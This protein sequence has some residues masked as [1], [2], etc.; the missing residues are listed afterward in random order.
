M[1]YTLNLVQSG[2]QYALFFLD[3][4]SSFIETGPITG[5][6]QS[7]GEPWYQFITG[8]QFT[9][10]LVA[11]LLIY[12][13]SSN[14]QYSGWTAVTSGLGYNTLNFNTQLSDVQ[15]PTNFVAV[16]TA[17]NE[18]FASFTL[19]N[20]PW[21]ITPD[22]S[23]ISI[24]S[25]ISGAGPVIPT[26]NADTNTYG[27]TFT[28]VPAGVYTL[29][30]YT[31]GYYFN[32]FD[33]GQTALGYMGPGW[34][35]SVSPDVFS[36]SVVVQGLPPPPPSPPPPALPAPNTMQVFNV[37]AQN[38]WGVINNMAS[39]GISDDFPNG[40][41]SWSSTLGSQYTHWEM[42]LSVAVVPQYGVI[43]AD[44]IEAGGSYAP[45]QYNDTDTPIP[46]NIALT[47][48]S[49]GQAYRM[50]A[51]HFM[52]YLGGGSSGLVFDPL[53]NI[54]QTSTTSDHFWGFAVYDHT[55]NAL[56]E[57]ISYND[58]IAA[59][60]SAG[61]AGASGW[62]NTGATGIENDFSGFVRNVVRTYMVPVPEADDT[63]NYEFDV[64]VAIINY[65]EYNALNNAYQSA[66]NGG[67]L[68]VAFASVAGDEDGD[69]SAGR[70]SGRINQSTVWSGTEPVTVNGIYTVNLFPQSGTS[71]TYPFPYEWYTGKTWGLPFVKAYRFNNPLLQILHV[72]S[73][74][75]ETFTDVVGASAMTTLTAL[76]DG[77]T[78][79][80]LIDASGP[81]SGTMEGVTNVMNL[82]PPFAWVNHNIAAHSQPS[83]AL[84]VFVQLFYDLRSFFG[85][86]L[87]ILQRLFS[88]I[89]NGITIAF[90]DFKS[91][92]SNP[93]FDNV[94][95]EFSSI[96]EDF[97][98]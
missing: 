58:C 94:I 27:A 98:V 68:T 37:F 66:T 89:R 91:L 11:Y 50:Y 84:G 88:A 85:R 86:L 79:G 12:G 65:N 4:E 44:D 60:V 97:A 21:Q 53:A 8:Q 87:G 67:T 16:S 26:F 6:T 90:G 7:D 45:Y 22:P 46:Y 34:V 14:T 64:S 39:K 13:L 63:G 82:Y 78:G 49:S 17:D 33:L 81:S 96:A 95:E 28:G 3:G 69:T 93:A 25:P 41:G 15:M 92:L 80:Q 48:G 20:E 47:E 9:T 23:D 83:G 35:N 52:V 74:S 57:L 59:S 42:N 61:A 73:T 62:F 24:D 40:Q 1:A 43:Y 36:S 19:T 71:L 31:E 30:A 10:T 5:L 70:L 54:V 56:V 77:I 55:N 2:G 51:V 32:V 75:L 38:P 18:I 76:Y 72:A 29:E